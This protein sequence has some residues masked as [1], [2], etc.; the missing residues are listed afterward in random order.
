MGRGRDGILY[1]P[2]CE[3][4]DVVALDEAN[5]KSSLPRARRD[6]PSSENYRITSAN[7]ETV[8]INNGDD[9]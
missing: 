9:L 1:C 2:D 3:G 4:N 7:D 6:I 5:A 8:Y